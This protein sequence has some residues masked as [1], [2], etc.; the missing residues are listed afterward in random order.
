MLL[1]LDAA[2]RFGEDVGR[3]DDPRSVN[4]VELFVFDVRA[5]E[6]ISYIN[7]LRASMRRVVGRQRKCTVVVGCNDKG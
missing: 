4:D 6:M 5:N 7:V 2:K 3:I 1:K